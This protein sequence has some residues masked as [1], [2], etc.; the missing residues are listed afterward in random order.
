MK[1]FF[2]QRLSSWFDSAEIFNESGDVIFHVEG[3]L[4]L[5]QQVDIYDAYNCH[6]A[7]LRQKKLSLLPRFDILI[8]GSSYGDMRRDLTSRHP[9][10]R[11]DHL[12]WIIE[13]NPTQWDYEI[14]NLTGEVIAYVSKE[15][16]QQ[17]DTYCLHVHHSRNALPALLVVLAL[18]M[19]KSK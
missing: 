12:G 7:A 14:K 2:S 13:G 10:F 15:L 1:L 3:Q 5:G 17:A 6:I 11:L 16:F 4:S 9:R 19:E 8:A 18:D